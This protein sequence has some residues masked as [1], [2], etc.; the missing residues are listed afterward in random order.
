MYLL[1]VFSV[2]EYIS[3]L[4]PASRMA[5]FCESLQGVGLG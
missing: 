2:S 5:A 1:F 4:N 3:L